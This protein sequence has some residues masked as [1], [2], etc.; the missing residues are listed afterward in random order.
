MELLPSIY[1]NYLVE[2]IRIGKNINFEKELAVVNMTLKDIKYPNE[3]KISYSILTKCI[4]ENLQFVP[5]ILMKK[6]QF[7][8]DKVNKKKLKLIKYYIILF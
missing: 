1:I 8:I 6:Y 4:E 3:T 5:L 7:I 2:L